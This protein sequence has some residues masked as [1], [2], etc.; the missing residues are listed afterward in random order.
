ML[1][2]HDVM[3]TDLSLLTTA[4]TEWDNAAK[5]FDQAKSSY[6]S[7]VKS[8]TTEG[9][10]LGISQLSAQ[11]RTTVGSE[12]L[13]A[14]AHEARAI[15]SLL[16]DA[17]TQFV[18][19]KNKVQAAVDDAVSNKMK[20]NEYGVCSWNG[21][22]ATRHDPELPAYVAKF[23]T[24]INDAVRAVD[25]AD[26]GAKLALAAATKSPDPWGQ[27][28][29]FNGKAVDDIE[30]VEAKRAADL[31][32][33]LD[34]GKLTPEELAEM[35]RLFRDNKADEAF[36]QTFLDSVG[37]KG[38]VE[39]NKHLR[40]LMGDDKKNKAA[41]E[42]LRDALATSLSTATQNTKSPFYNKWREGLRK[43][44]V[45]DFKSKGDQTS[46]RG[47]QLLVDLMGHGKGYNKQ[48]LSDLGDDMIAAEKKTDSLWT[49]WG[50]GH[51]GY[52][53]DPVNGLLSIM[54]RQPDAAT[55]FL[56]PGAD[57]KANDH[58][59]YLLN[60]RKW[61][62]EW[63]TTPVGISETGKPFYDYI[64]RDG[65]GAA[66]EAAATGELPG[67][68]HE[69]GGHTEAQARVMQSTVNLLNAGGHPD[70][71]HAQLRNPIANMLADYT[72][73]THHTLARDFAQYNEANNT[74]GKVWTDG[75][76]THL[77][78]DKFR[79]AKLMRGVADDPAS[80]ATMYA[81]ERQYA[82]NVLGVTD[83]RNDAARAAVIGEASSAL[84]FYDGVRADVIL[85]KRDA[86]IQWATDVR[87]HVTTSS[88]VL[89]NFIPSEVA[90]GVDMPKGVKVGAD[91][92]NRLTDF[93]MYEW[94]NDQV[95]EAK[96]HAGAD[97]ANSFIN[98]QKEVDMLASEWAKKSGI[99]NPEDYDLRNMIRNAHGDHLGARD[100]V[101][102]ALNRN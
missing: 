5:E 63:T 70:K 101:F 27:P 24:A 37:P 96:S 55:Y 7:E 13:G 16:R 65:L 83:F 76:G 21:D 97:N 54:S 86:A 62:T 26:Q 6:D 50:N 92:L 25:D 98:G 85:D 91:V 28:N 12:Q 100:E 90:P 58:L 68:K 19:L 99:S 20:V 95:A 77:A 43:A 61:P 84:G 51:P 49:K 46:L 73:D 2:Y 31:K 3:T 32:T 80:F 57:G 38:T 11:N 56:D 75:N 30:K 60:D 52:V 72:A 59:K 44:G 40:D 22:D 4:A 48:F 39:F 29:G 74:D 9:T 36:T 81:A 79:L 15:A 45:E 23:T 1:S 82:G 64:G 14:A 18:D 10:W 17:H 34:G 8:V 89:L 41:Y 66:M 102:V 78:V 71:L 87:H 94:Y 47:Y 67:S 53:Q 88:G 69:L 35:Q 33:K 42:D 93:A